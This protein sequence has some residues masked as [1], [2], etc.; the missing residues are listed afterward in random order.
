MRSRPAVPLSASRP[1]PPFRLRPTGDGKG[2]RCGDVAIADVDGNRGGAK[3]VVGGG[4]G[5]S[6]IGP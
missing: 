6:T 3:L 2:G 5:K 4:D 1:L